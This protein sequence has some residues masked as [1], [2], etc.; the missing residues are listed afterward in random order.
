MTEFN[1]NS[2]AESVQ[3]PLIQ[4]YGLGQLAMRNELSAVEQGE[5]SP[6][7][8]VTQED[9]STFADQYVQPGTDARV[10]NTL[11]TKAYT[12]WIRLYFRQRRG[13]ELGALP[14]IEFWKQPKDSLGPELNRDD[15]SDQAINLASAVAFM[16]AYRELDDHSR[17]YH[18]LPLPVRNKMLDF[19]DAFLESQLDKVS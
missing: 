8:Y 18:E 6:E 4:Q 13:G 10:K 15:A 14:R 16:H 12:G 17:I 11:A 5:T 19:Y 7:G 1:Q 2:A 9:F 3:P